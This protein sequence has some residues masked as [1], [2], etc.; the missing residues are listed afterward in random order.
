MAARCVTEAFRCPP[1]QCTYRGLWGLVWLTVWLKHLT[2]CVAEWFYCQLKDPRFKF[3][4]LSLAIRTSFF[5]HLALSLGPSKI[6]NWGPGLGWGRTRRLTG[7]TVAHTT[8]EGHS[9]CS[10]E[11]TSLW[12]TLP[13]S[14]VWKMSA[15]DLVLLGW[16][17]RSNE[18]TQFFSCRNVLR[19]FF[20][21]NS[22][23]HVT[24]TIFSFKVH[25][26]PRTKQCRLL[27]S[28]PFCFWLQNFP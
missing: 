19:S 18:G 10:Y 13:T 24:D 4:Q 27:P 20:Q 8:V 25:R 15:T 28:K 6:V 9:Q 11:C 23:W 26:S 12:K 17:L 7:F 14:S 22:V 2:D 1:V 21:L 3:H 5:L 16:W